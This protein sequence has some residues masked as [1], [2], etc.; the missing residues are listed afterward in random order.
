[1][2]ILK[3]FKLLSIYLRPL[4]TSE[5]LSSAN[6]SYLMGNLEE[7][8]FF[9]SPANA[10]TVFRRMHQDARDP[11]EG[12]GLLP[13]PDATN[14]DP[15]PGILCQPLFTVSVLMEHSEELGEFMELKGAS[16]LGILVLTTGLSKPFM[17]LDKYPA[18]LKELERHMEVR[19]PHWPR[20]E[21]QSGASPGEGITTSLYLGRVSQ[22]LCW[23]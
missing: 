11:T 16:S 8:C 9:F 22:G 10:C 1:M 4:Q 20:Q 15:V 12:R 23:L 6:T 18:L 3:N 21:E 13:Q 7:I 19:L 5:K 14:E 2:N 17:R